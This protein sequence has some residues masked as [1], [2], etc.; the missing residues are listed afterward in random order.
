MVVTTGWGVEE[1]V[2]EGEILIHIDQ[3]GPTFTSMVVDW[4][5]LRNKI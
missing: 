1:A 3:R 2:G 5:I 4:L